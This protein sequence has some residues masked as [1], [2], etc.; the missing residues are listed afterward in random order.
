MT[1]RP[2]APSTPR[3][4]TRS[5]QPLRWVGPNTPV[6]IRSWKIPGGLFYLQPGATNQFEPSAIGVNLNVATPAIGA[7]SALP[8]WPAYATITP[9]Q[10]GTYLEWMARGRRDDN[11]QT[12]EFGYLFLFFYGL[13]RRVLIEEDYCP[14]IGHEIANLVVIYS[15]YGRSKSLQSYFCQLLHFWAHRQ[16]EER[17][18]EL[19]PWI[20]DL[21][22]SVLDEDELALVLG[23]LAARGKNAPAKLAREIAYNDPAAIRSNVTTR[24]PEEFARLF[25]QRF[26]L[27]FPNGLPVEGSS[28]RVVAAEYRPASAALRDAIGTPALT[29]HTIKAIIPEP[30]RVKLIELWNSSCNDLLSYM[31]A[32]AKSVGKSVDLGTLVAMPE[33]FRKR[34]ASNLAAGLEQIL[35]SAAQEDGYHFITAGPL[36]S[37]FG[38]ANRPKYTP[39][40]SRQMATGLGALGWLLEPDPNMHGGSLSSDSEVVLFRGTPGGISPEFLGHCGLVQLAASI[41]GADGH[42]DLRESETISLLIENAAVQ[43]T[44]KIRLRAWN[45]LLSRNLDNAPAGITKVTKAVPIEKAQAVAQVLCRIASADGIVT[46]NEERALQRIFKSLGLTRE[47]EM[48]FKRYLAGFDE[49]AVATGESESGATG[50]AIPPRPGTQPKFTINRERLQQLTA[51]TAEVIHILS[52]A[53]AD[54]EHEPTAS[55]ATTPTQAPRPVQIVVPDWCATLK[56]AYVPITIDLIKRESWTRVEFDALAREHHVMAGAAYDAIN[57]WSDEALGDFLLTGDDPVQINREVLPPS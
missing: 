2:A 44:E 6:E 50:E 22:N 40:Q 38:E 11:P 31:R 34:H 47:M 5:V 12:R 35:A 25:D 42:F 4:T 24:S 56:S 7:A 30:A 1:G 18:G 41:A 10:R 26:T 16:G 28:K 52:V 51:E 19:W 53:M 46:K 36:F 3:P 48:E 43:E 45:A 14:E 17:Y 20:L 37:Y 27:E 49:V 29:A 8:Y 57:E 33:E 13:E 32:K 23:N 39:S 54:A 15:P 55:T 21:T 9:A